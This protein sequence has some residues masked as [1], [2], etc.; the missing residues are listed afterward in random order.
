MRLRRAREAEPSG[1]AFFRQFAEALQKHAE[2][3]DRPNVETRTSP[4]AAQSARRNF[5]LDGQNIATPRDHATRPDDFD[6]GQSRVPFPGEG[7]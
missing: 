3:S 5:S 1:V 4:T 6:V 7:I 2:G